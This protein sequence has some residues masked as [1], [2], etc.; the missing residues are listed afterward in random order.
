MIQINETI[1]NACISKFDNEIIDLNNSLLTK[2]KN[3]K[4]TIMQNFHLNKNSI[5][6]D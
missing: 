5:L 4:K 1:L 2:V 6:I 3:F